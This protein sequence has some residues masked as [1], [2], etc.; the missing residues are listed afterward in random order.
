MFTIK[1]LLALATFVLPLV[2]AQFVTSLPQCIQNCIT[3]SQDD[4]CEVSDIACLCR[5]SAGNFLPDLVT[6]IHGNCDNDLDNNIFLAP[7]QFA[8]EIAGAPIPESAL[9]NAENDASS[10]AS[11]LTTTVTMGGASATGSSETMTV[12]ESATPSLSTVT[13]TTTEGG[14]TL[15]IVYPVTEWLTSTLSGSGS[16]LTSLSTM[17]P[18]IRIVPL[19]VIGTDSAGSTY[20]STTTQPGTLSTYT[21]T[22]SMGH[23]TTQESTYTETTTLSPSSSSSSS[24][25]SSSSDSSTTIVTTS[26]AAAKTSSSNTSAS[27]TS[28]APSEDSTNSSPFKNTNSA[29][30]ERVGGNPFLG[31]GILLVM[32]IMW[33]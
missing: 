22:D 25:S 5:A 32:G 24:A 9:K 1:V 28:T 3:Q 31:L 12:V 14:S 19:V 16:T 6:C 15:G 20:T 2:L 30:K 29:F 33:F 17:S 8:C 26:L 4:N 23:T 11:Q 7:L 27:K 13:V 18:S 21:T 10:L